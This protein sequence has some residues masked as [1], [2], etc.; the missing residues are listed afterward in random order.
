[1]SSESLI[2][3]SACLP[4]CYASQYRRGE[5]KTGD[6]V[7]AVETERWRCGVSRCMAAGQVVDEVE[8]VSATDRQELVRVSQ[9]RE[10][11]DDVASKEL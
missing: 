10:T 4:G 6:D 9:S 7:R 11:G 3:L 5:G 1:M 8:D 2:L